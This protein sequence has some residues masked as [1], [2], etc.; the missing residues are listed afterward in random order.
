M[1]GAEVQ[2]VGEGETE[3]AEGWGKNREAGEPRKNLG[4]GE[5]EEA[6]GKMRRKE[7]LKQLL[8]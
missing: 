2:G 5:N 6:G 3:D 7:H 8:K 1:G 4:R